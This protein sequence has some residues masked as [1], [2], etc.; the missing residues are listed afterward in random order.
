MD[1]IL[2]ALQG[3]AF[4]LSDEVFI[5]LSSKYDELI[6]LPIPGCGDYGFHKDFFSEAIS[7][8]R[9]QFLTEEYIQSRIRNKTTGTIDHLHAEITAGIIIELGKKEGIEG[10]AIELLRFTAHLHDSDRS[11]PKLMIQGED[12]VRR[13]P[14][15]YSLFKEKHARNSADIAIRIAKKTHEMGF[16]FG[17]GFLEDLEYMILNHEKGGNRDAADERRRSTVNPLL[18]LDHLTD[19]LTDSDSLAYFYANILTNWEESGRSTTALSNKVR[20]MFDRMSLNGQQMMLNTIL[21][22][23]GHILGTNNHHDPDVKSIRSILLNLCRLSE[24][25]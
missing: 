21:N 22:S 20:F 2:A 5:F 15:E 7:E 13:N 14:G 16:S 1:R 25:Q 18:H 23:S 24:R 6:S 11:F 10:Y 17:E 12:Q 3:N 4:H 9:N 19:L 8:H